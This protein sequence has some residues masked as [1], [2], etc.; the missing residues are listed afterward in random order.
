[1]S[2]RHPFSPDEVQKMA[3]D[4]MEKG[5]HPSRVRRYLQQ[6]G[7]HWSYEYTGQL[8]GL[9]AKRRAFRRAGLEPCACGGGKKIGTE[10]CDTCLEKKWAP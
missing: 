7:I 4:L 9:R 10:M 8:P 5:M 6:Y 2:H 3:A 1:M